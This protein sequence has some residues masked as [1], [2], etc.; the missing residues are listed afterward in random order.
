MWRPGQRTQ[1]TVGGR[2]APDRSVD[3]LRVERVDLGHGVYQAS[4]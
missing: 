4:A 2:R 3:E 1:A